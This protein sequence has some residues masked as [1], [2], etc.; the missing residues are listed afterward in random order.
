M[1]DLHS[2]ASRRRSG[3]AILLSA[4]AIILAWMLRPDQVIRAQS[5]P[6]TSA[7]SPSNSPP[8]RLPALCAIRID[9]FVTVPDS[10]GDVSTACGLSG[11]ESGAL[12]GLAWAPFD[13]ARIQANSDSD[14]LPAY[15]A[16]IPDGI[17]I[18]IVNHADERA[19]ATISARLPRGVYTIE[20]I[21]FEVGAATL[22]GNSERLEPVILG[23][24]A[25]VTK[26]V[27]L[28]PH[29]VA[30]YRITN[31]SQQVNRGF[32]AVKSRF[33]ALRAADPKGWKRMA[34]P[35]RECES[36][37]AVI[38]RGISPAGRYDAL[39]Y[40][41]RALLTLAHVQSI[42]RNHR[43]ASVAAARM[44][45]AVSRLEEG[46][47]EMS[48]GCL[49]L[50]PDLAISQPDDSRPDMREVTVSI[51]NRGR[52]TLSVVKIGTTAP[53]GTQITPRDQ[54]MF[55]S[56]GPG[57]TVSASFTVQSATGIVGLIAD[58]AYFAARVPAHLR[59]KPV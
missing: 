13:G 38:G 19:A 54:A 21:G 18:C 27:W 29:S 12:P 17:A 5:D 48:A 43:S 2:V 36:N 49:I 20:R 15:A 22:P 9:A 24:T 4:F 31:R 7:A 1:I 6:A 47:A 39:R 10:Q 11:A 33:N 50:V 26:P 59:L 58:I 3:A 25:T 57:Q 53:R 37:I 45:V 35:M 41:H 8:L 14:L 52:Q 46:L 16:K 40:V 23:A 32:R 44:E 55:R 28:L 34:A 56:L 42:C 51:A 30:V